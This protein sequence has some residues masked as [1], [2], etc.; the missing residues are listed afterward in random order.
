MT[1]RVY[2]WFPPPDCTYVPVPVLGLLRFEVDVFCYYMDVG[3]HTNE[4]FSL[5]RCTWSIYCDEDTVHT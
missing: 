1:A 3:C 4:C 2:N 5:E